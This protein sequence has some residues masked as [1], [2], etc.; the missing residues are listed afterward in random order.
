MDVIHILGKHLHRLH[1]IIRKTRCTL[2]CTHITSCC[3]LRLLANVLW[4]PSLLGDVVVGIV[5]DSMDI[6]EAMSWEGDAERERRAS[7]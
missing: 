2:G 5:A 1:L 4:Y 7:E 6:G 3:E